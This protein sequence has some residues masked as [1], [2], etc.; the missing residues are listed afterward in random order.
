LGFLCAGA[1][2]PF[3]YILYKARAL[4][5]F[6]VVKVVIPIAASGSIMI[7]SIVYQRQQNVLEAPGDLFGQQGVKI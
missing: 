1:P 2:C 3:G 6:I 7:L 4:V 5:D